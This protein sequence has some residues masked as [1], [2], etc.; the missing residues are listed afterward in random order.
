MAETVRMPWIRLAVLILV[1][2]LGAVPAAA[3]PLAPEAVPEPLRPWV[4]WVLRGHEAQ[5]CPFLHGQG[6]RECVW[7]GRLE[8]ALDGSGGR[9]E[10][11]LFVAA[12]SDVRLPGAL[13]SRTGLDLGIADDEILPADVPVALALARLLRRLGVEPAVAGLAERR[14]RPAPARCGRAWRRSGGRT[15]PGPARRWRPRSR[16]SGRP[17][18][19]A[20]ARA[21]RGRGRRAAPAGRSGGARRR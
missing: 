19:G 10:Q 11:R 1:L 16:G 5:A 8:L 15:P 7:P 2:C 18:A 4:D 6:E 14:G 17:R 21:A 12:E 3:A 20:V 13:E 9:F